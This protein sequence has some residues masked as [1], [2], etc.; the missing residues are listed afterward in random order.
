MKNNSLTMQA[1][2]SRAALLFASAGIL[3]LAVS[4]S[5]DGIELSETQNQNSSPNSQRVQSLKWAAYPSSD[6]RESFYRLSTET[7][8]TASV[9]KVNDAT[10]GDVFAVNKPSGSKRAELSR[11]EPSQGT[12]PDYVPAEGDLVYI[13]WRQKI[14]IAGNTFPSGG[15]AVFQNKSND[16]H[17]QNYPFLMG[18]DGKTLTLTKYVSG[19]GSQESRGTKIWSKAVS[20]NSWATIV[21]GVKFSKNSSTGY[22]QLWHNGSAQDLVGDDS[23]RKVFHRTL[24]DNGNYFKWGAYNETSRN[25]NITNYL[26]NMKIATTYDEAR[27]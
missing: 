20:E 6:Y 5:K 11:T 22:I 15:F 19:S 2:K 21:L 24:D 13:G 1:L 8:E 3:A 9:S 25:F 27:P 23:S 18:Y 14:N 17:S 10:Y 4:C 7:G 16:P 12:K 26:T